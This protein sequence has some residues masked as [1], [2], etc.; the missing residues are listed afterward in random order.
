M[1]SPFLLQ[2]RRLRSAN[3]GGRVSFSAEVYS[4]GEGNKL[5]IA[6]LF[7]GRSGEHDVSLQSAA[8]VIEAMD[9]EKYNIVP[10]GITEEG[11]W[12]AGGDP[13][14]ALLQKDIP[15]TSTYVTLATKPYA[16]GL[17]L[18][19][20]GSASV[21]ESFIPLDAVFPVLHGTNGED[22]TVQGLLELAGLPY[23]GAGV[24][25]SATAM[26]K[27]VMKIL[28]RYNNLP[29]GDF[30]YFSAARWEAEEEELLALIEKRFDY[31]C[32]I[33]PANLGSSVGVSKV[34][35]REMLRRGIQEALRYDLKVIVEEFIPGRELE[36]SV[37][38]DDNPL[39]SVPGEVIP[40]NDFY[41]YQAKYLDQRSRLL[42]PAPLEPEREKELKKLAVQ[43]FEAVECSGLGRVDF[44]YCEEEQQIYINEINT[45]PGFTSI[46]MYPK[47]WEASGLPYTELIDKLIEIAL[48]RHARQTRLETK[49]RA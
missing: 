25:S 21:A 44:F 49:F 24:L 41:D 35:S 12:L 46:S 22:G 23:V 34:S 8:S 13:L 31:P 4:V 2:G 40:C 29:Q 28:F 27:A 38:G 19:D 3:G 9:K 11:L 6:V 47:L 30:F 17:V 33:K 32:F 43:A 16:P 39:A 1:I 45:M 37:L 14:Q 48:R 20:M 10:V 36:C 18:L 26:D 7:G 42:I 5:T 15:G